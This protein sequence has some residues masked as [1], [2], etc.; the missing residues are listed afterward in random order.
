MLLGIS[1]LKK[2]EYCTHVTHVHVTCS[3]G[4]LYGIE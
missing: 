2:C 3:F 1:L 4:V